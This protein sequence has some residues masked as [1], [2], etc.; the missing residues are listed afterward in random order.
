MNNSSDSVGA[1]ENIVGASD[2]IGENSISLKF[3]TKDKKNNVALN[4]GKVN[5]NS[6]LHISAAMGVTRILR[7]GGYMER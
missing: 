6:L 1:S 7:I 2:N 4:V 3:Q 5:K